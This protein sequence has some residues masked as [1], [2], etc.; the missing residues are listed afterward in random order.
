MVQ[1]M[2]N[3]KFGEPGHGKPEPEQ[4]PVKKAALRDVQNQTRSHSFIT[5]SPVSKNSGKRPSPEQ[6]P[7]SQL[8]YV[9]RKSEAEMGKV[10]ACDG[11]NGMNQLGHFSGE[12]DP[13]VP[14]FSAFAVPTRMDST[15]SGKANDAQSAPR[16]M[17]M[18]PS[19]HHHPFASDTGKRVHWEE[20]Y[21][22]LQVSLKK[23]DGSDHEDYIQMLRSISSVELSRHAVELEKRSI[24]L[25]LEEAKEIQRVAY[26][27]VLGRNLRPTFSVQPQLH[28]RK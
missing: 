9:R 2:M 27:N 11:S 22:Q 6:S 18:Q 12:K 21:R 23:L 26:L 25:S 28:S 15:I 1:Q 14:R 4:F 20:R 24:Q 5:R 10:G 8:V 16:F 17:S 19:Y 3:S 7:N 13:K